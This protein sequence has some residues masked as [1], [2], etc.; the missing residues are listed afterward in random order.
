MMKTQKIIGGLIL[1][2]VLGVVQS[3]AAT[4]TN[5]AVA[6]ST[7]TSATV[8]WTTNSAS[9]S[10]VLYGLN[11][12]TT[13]STTTDQH[14]VTSH[15][16]T[17]TGLVAG[18][19]YS[20]KVSSIDTG[21]VSTS[22]V[23]TFQLCSGGGP[24]AGYTNVTGT[25]GVA[26]A[27]GLL[28][29]TWVN[30]SGVS[31]SSPTICGVAFPT[32]ITSVLTTTGNLA[33]QLP[34]NNSIIP[35][36]GRWQLSIANATGNVGQFSITT[37]ITGNS[38]GLTSQLQTAASGQLQLTY[39]DPATGS[40]DP[41]IS[42]APS[43]GQTQSLSLLP[44]SINFNTVQTLTPSGAVTVNIANTGTLAVTL[45]FASFTNSD[46]SSPNSTACNGILQSGA[47]CPFQVIYTPSS[48]ASDVGTLNFTTDIAAL[49]NRSVSLSGIGTSAATYPLN[50]TSTDNGFGTV[51][52]SEVP[53]KI[54]CIIAPPNP[55]TGNC[56]TNYADGTA[57]RLTA[58]NG[59]ASLFQSFNGASCSVSPCDLV[60]ASPGFTVT[61]DFAL[62]APVV[63]PSG[64]VNPTSIPFGTVTTG[65][66]SPVQ[67]V[68]ISN[69]ST[70]LPLT[71]NSV[72]ISDSHF[73]SSNQ[74]ICNGIFSPLASCV[75]PLFFTPT[76]GVTSTGT[77]T[78]NTN[79]PIDPTN[80]LTLLQVSLSGTGTA[81]ATF[82]LSIN[83]G[84]STGSGRVTS[85]VG[86]INCLIAPPAAPSG[87]CSVNFTTG[88]I[89]TLTALALNGGTFAS[90]SGCSLSASPGA[91][92]VSAATT[93]AA[94]FN[95]PIPTFVLTVTGTGQG[96]GT[97]TSDVGGISCNSNAGVLSGACSATFDDGTVINLTESPSGSCTGGAC[98]FNQWTGISGC[99]TA[100]TCVVTLH[101]NVTASGDFVQ[102][103]GGSPLTKIQT[104][105]GGTPGGAAIAFVQACQNSATAPTNFTS[106][107]VNCNITPGN[108]VIAF[109]RSVET[110]TQTWTVSDSAGQSWSQ[111]TSGY[112]A[113]TNNY[114]AGMHYFSNSA[115][116]T[117]VT[118]NF[119]T[120]QTNDAEL[121]VL[122]F[123]GLAA[124]SLE[125]SSVNAHNDSGSTTITSGA[126]TTTNANDVLIFCDAAAGAAGPFTAGASYTIPTNGQSNT[127]SACQYR[128]VAGTVSGLQV[129][130]TSTGAFVAVDIFAGFKGTAANTT[131]TGNW[132]QAQNAADLIVCKAAWSDNTTTVSAVADTKGN[133]YT[134]VTNSPKTI[135][136]LSVAMY[137]AQNILAA[138]AGANTTTLTLTASPTTKKLECLE[139]SGAPTSGALDASVGATGT[140]TA[141][142]S[143]NVTST[144]TNDFL[145]GADAVAGTI[146]ANSP[147]FTQQIS[148]SIGDVEDRSV[149]TA[150]AYSFTP[151]QSTAVNWAALL[152]AFKTSGTTPTFTV[153]LA[154]AGTGSGTI[155]GGGFNCTITAGVLSGVCSVIATS[156]S[157]LSIV[158]SPTGGSAFVTYTGGGCSTQANCLTAAITTN[159]VITA[160]FSI[161]GARNFFVN[162]STGSDNNSGLCAV[163]GTPAGCTGPWATIEKADNTITLGPTGVCT[164][165]SG[166]YSA[167]GYAACVHV[168]SATYNIGAEQI[169]DKAGTSATLRVG[170]IS[171]TKYGA[172]VRQN[173]SGSSIIWLDRGQWSD[174]IGFDVSTNQSGT[175]VG[176]YGLD[177]NADHIR[178]IGNK[179]HDIA[180]G[181]CADAGGGGITNSS[182]ATTDVQAIGNTV[183]KVGTPGSCRFYH[184]I[185]FNVLNPVIENNLA[186]D[187]AAWGL[188]CRHICS[189]G[190]ISNN[191]VFANGGYGLG[192]GPSSGN[193]LVC[194]TS[195]TLSGVGGGI[196]VG[197]DSGSETTTT[198]TNNI[199]FN[200]GAANGVPSGYGCG[201]WDFHNTLATSLVANNIVRNDSTGNG[202]VGGTACTNTVGGTGGGIAVGLSATVTGNLFVVPGFVN[203]QSDG[204]GNYS[205]TAVSPARNAATLNCAPGISNCTPL[206]DFTF[207]APRPQGPAID[208]GAYEVP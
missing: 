175:N 59:A 140:G 56:S 79:A 71:V 67:N 178:F 130:M 143:G 148:T 44:T 205:L 149:T 51:L 5:I 61:A 36:P 1:W 206:N 99:T 116:L 91:C 16:V 105:T 127:R 123:S 17:V 200:N 163:A 166:W 108:G 201:I 40:F 153:S 203:Y 196:L 52:S 157:T 176:T 11:G 89:V 43:G 93:V 83:G 76:A 70:T 8:T 97:I 199:V 25:V 133:T 18:Q 191:T 195:G 135:A 90:F 155:T 46:F 85:D 68:S 111:T 60:I 100:S 19:V 207:A 47:V 177:A 106:L 169:Q 194:C 202:A 54:N 34:D 170:W 92:T 162:G 164:A 74:N 13:S 208:I 95:A 28:S 107:T 55:P 142:S 22:S 171:D 139:Y 183:F 144:V 112:N 172:L 57:V 192:N 20:Y 190:I 81:L 122:E 58:T 110:N 14:L 96:I 103:A 152:A 134:Q 38:I 125:D 21:G 146:T 23:N 30:D 27:Q 33:L 145:V 65:T 3:F 69:T 104:I 9:T 126:L 82:P 49:P 10:Q 29:A 35:S 137:Y 45:A 24:T 88:T 114:R 129:S 41:P 187:N 113:T 39:Y 156:G 66:T 131:V 173:A 48:V 102:P 26:Y 75:V 181:A 63:T 150:G 188:T 80:P 84:T 147:N 158:A 154:G 87:I 165:A 161:G 50:V 32:T 78:V 186:Y 121:I 115:A 124:A 189:G 193:P 174:I 53:P 64:A 182:S 184:G 159:T 4:I 128:I 15:S 42:A 37:A 204:S 185:Y 119:G 197:N 72:I 167:S 98:T 120:T 12:T 77:L 136:G 73:T 138:L 168:A 117:S 94:N 141:I 179:V 109:V 7:G 180:T 101:A 132:A 86:G 198:I 151:T 118:V 6:S 160:N 62:T 2:L 31:T